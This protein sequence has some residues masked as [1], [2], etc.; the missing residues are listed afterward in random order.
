M[1]WS[2]PHEQADRLMQLDGDGL[3]KEVESASKGVLGSL[4]ALTTAQAFPLRQSV[5]R[6][7][8]LPH[9]ALVGDAAHAIHPLAGQGLNLGLQD[10]RSLGS[11]IAGREPI[12]GL[13]DLRLLRRYERDRAEAILAM[14][15]GVHGLYSLF[16]SRTPAAGLLRN[17]GLNL[18]NRLP[19]IK[20]ILLRHAL[21]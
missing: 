19:V 20:N 5:V 10:V 4:R 13:G 16:E 15:A 18:T 3:A 9:L 1:V 6:R 12:R 21:T 7:M 11:V 8:V 14:R 17:T 2:V